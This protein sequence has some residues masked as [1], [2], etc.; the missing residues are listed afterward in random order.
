MKQQIITICEFGAYWGCTITKAEN[1]MIE[2][3]LKTGLYI[4][5]QEQYNSFWHC[6]QLAM[7]SSLQLKER[8]GGNTC[9]FR[10]GDGVW[11]LLGGG[12]G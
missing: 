10:T 5:L 12:L 4:S 1:N 2:R 9:W 3:C 11:I 7:M 8:K 6:L